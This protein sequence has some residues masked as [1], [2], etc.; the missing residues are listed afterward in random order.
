[1]GDPQ[2]TFFDQSQTDS[3]GTFDFTQQ[4]V[5]EP[6]VQF[7]PTAEETK[8]NA[9]QKSSDPVETTAAI[10]AA[11]A[12]SSVIHPTIT[13]TNP[14]VV[15]QELYGKPMPAT[16]LWDK[17]K[18]LVGSG[19]DWVQ[20]ADSKIAGT[21][22]SIDAT[23]RLNALSQR[24]MQSGGPGKN[25][26]LDQQIADLSKK[27]D[28]KD[29]LGA[30]P[31]FI[32]GIPYQL[33]YQGLTAADTVA[34]E[35]ASLVTLEPLRKTFGIM[36]G[37]NFEANAA[38]GASALLGS[39]T[40]A[41][42]RGR[43][44]AGV[45]NT[46]ATWTAVG[47][48]L[49]QAALFA[50]KIPG[51]G[52]A[53]ESLAGA[54]ATTLD[55]LIEGAVAKGA[56][57]A[58]AERV[59]FEAVEKGTLK[60]AL[61]GALSATA[62]RIALPL[63]QQTSYG[64]LGAAVNDSATVISDV[65]HNAANENKIPLPAATQI[66]ADLGIGAAG[67]LV[68]GGM[69]ELAGVGSRLIKGG[70]LDR[71]VNDAAAQ[72]DAK[73]VE[74]PVGETPHPIEVATA[75]KMAT[76]TVGDILEKPPEVPS[77]EKPGEP[78]V[79]PVEVPRM[80]E[81]QGKALD[82]ATRS[83]EGTSNYIEKRPEIEKLNTQI[84]DLQAKVQN[85]KDEYRAQLAVAKAEKVAAVKSLR[86][87][88]EQRVETNRM[89][90]NI[91][92]LDTSK[93]PS[94]FKAPLDSLLEIYNT[95]KPTTKTLDKLQTIRDAIES[96]AAPTVFSARDLAR[97]GELSKYP[98]RDLPAE[99]QKTVHDAIM[100]YYT[101]GRDSRIIH[102]RDLAIAAQE[103]VTAAVGEIG[104]P[105]I[106][107]DL[108]RFQAAH[109]QLSAEEA[110]AQFSQLTKGGAVEDMKK[111]VKNLTRW[112]KASN[113]GYES[114]LSY[115]GGGEDSFLYRVAGKMVD[116]GSDTYEAKKYEYTDPIFAWLKDKKLNMAAF[117]N[118]RKQIDV[119]GFTG[120]MER[121]HIIA[122]AGLKSTES[123]WESLQN[124]FSL[125][126]D[127]EHG[128]VYKLPESSLNEILATMDETDK[129]FLQQILD[130]GKKTGSDMAAVFRKMYGY[131][132]K[133]LDPY[134][135]IYRV[136]AELGLPFE[137]EI[138]RQRDS[139]SLTHAGVDKSHTIERVGS[140][141]PVWLRNVGSDMMDMVD[142]AAMFTG[143]AE[144]VRN[145]SRLIFN[146]DFAK[147]VRDKFGEEFYTQ[148]TDGVKAIAGSKKPLN[149]IERFTLNIRNR[150]IGAVLGFNLG[151]SAINR[152]LVERSLAGYIPGG[153][154]TQGQAYV[155][156]HPKSTH[157]YLFENS[158]LYRQI[159]EGG[160]MREIQDVLASKGSTRGIGKAL[161]K[162]QKASMTPIKLGF[163][164]ATK[165]E[166][167]SAITQARRELKAGTPSLD[168]QRAADLSDR[169][170][171]NMSEDAKQAAA[172]KYAE[173]VV[174]RTHA[175]PREMYAAN[176][177]RQ[178]TLG[179]LA[180]T[181]M[182]EKNA[183]LQ[184]GIRRAIDIKTPGGGKRFA[185]YLVVG[186]LGEALTIAGI[187]AGVA[188]VSAIA[189]AVITGQEPKKG[190]SFLVDAITEL[191]SNT[192]GLGIFLGN[193][194][195]PIEQALTSN[196]PVSSNNSLIGQFGDDLVK[197]VQDIHKGITAKT[198]K[199]RDKGWGDAFESF[200]SFAVP[201]VTRVP[202][203][204]GIGDVVGLY[205]KATQ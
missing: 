114:M 105:K 173:Y 141:K 158:T 15:S 84:E 18:S 93:I 87:Q 53:I 119:P 12:L 150:G 69:A 49:A 14:S 62:K 60:P 112:Y 145:A 190:K 189:T 136:L 144:P 166:M 198:Q 3:G 20:Q 194:V 38:W 96:G 89:I 106:T 24:Q 82:E 94:E 76:A 63:V 157:D 137:E 156:I 23:N 17:I 9:I 182:S 67:G 16:G 171:P 187:R 175:N 201:L 111:F 149:A 191:A 2:I 1:M 11:Q 140:T 40:G 72:I 108:A 70:F 203:K 162:L 122:M 170:G 31:S 21:V 134:Y 100:A 131:D 42:Y 161:D 186:V 174:K 90:R 110:K 98:F 91:R 153:D 28:P 185:K 167:W 159:W 154:W 196:M 37:T 192:V 172:I 176:I 92:T 33:G 188:E 107:K 56:E 77:V 79:K 51:L 5:K 199:A 61:S 48:G 32:L 68:M 25:P 151:T 41:V 50:V 102:D 132:L 169:D 181:L 142:S 52:K 180:G 27:A 13:A 155:A 146:P 179:M 115:L 130:M 66:L 59:I 22:G 43:L 195:Y 103:A 46:N 88:I 127:K 45:S 36:P 123:G 4:P 35:V 200:M 64:I 184:L 148:L 183:L 125:Q 29:H 86:D 104:S 58:A 6:Q 129:G 47:A 44:A 30:V 19:L 124:G 138:L 168:L 99:A 178:G 128:K 118:E 10:Q 74:V 8:Q 80:T 26:E 75:E 116:A 113:M 65:V 133:L 120:E 78:S 85:G 163:A 57:R 121:G 135:P 54:G 71:A 204:H 39:F 160:S 101:A 95:T 7:F 83:E 164:G 97:L 152:I 34:N 73:A 117:L 197:M 205:R 177:K 55:S 165:G 139:S 202:Y 109:P 143:L 81:A 193:L 126:G 147:A